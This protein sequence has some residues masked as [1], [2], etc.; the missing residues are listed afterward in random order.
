LTARI[1]AADEKNDVALLWADLK[2]R[3]V[4]PIP[5]GKGPTNL[6]SRVFT[7][8]Y[9]HSDLLGISPKV[10]SGELSG[11]LPLDPTK[12]LISVPVQS[13][14]SGGPLINMNG[15][16]VGLVIQKLSATKVFKATGDLT[17]N[18]NFALRIKY[19]DALID[20]QPKLDTGAGFAKPKGSQLEDWV[21]TYKD[22]IFF[23]LGSSESKK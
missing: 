13:G 23:V 10:T 14:N 12:I 15:E 8:G 16:A 21:S 22:S 19:V 4:R 6:G 5:F 18:T 11:M 3:S 1:V 7:I 2:G 20:D 9:P 17:E